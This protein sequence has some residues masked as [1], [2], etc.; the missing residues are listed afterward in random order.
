[1]N[2]NEKEI[3]TE[4]DRRWKK[5]GFAVVHKILSGK[6]ASEITLFKGTFQE[7]LS[8]EG[9]DDLIELLQ[10]VKREAF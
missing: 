9:L 6:P 3:E 10:T 7:K 5:N 2:N 1:M 8:K 4:V